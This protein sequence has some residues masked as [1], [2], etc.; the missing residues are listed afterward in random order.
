MIYSVSVTRRHFR[1]INFYLGEKTKKKINLTME[2]KNLSWNENPSKRCNH[3][4]VSQGIRGMIIGK[5][6]CGKNTSL[7]NLQVHPDWLD[8]KNINIFGKSLF[9]Q[10]IISSR[11]I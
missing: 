10:S 1:T 6:G 11:I 2:I 4:F 8:Y 7:I 3:P 5:Y 9:Q